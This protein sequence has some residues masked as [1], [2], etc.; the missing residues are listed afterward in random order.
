MEDG[1]VVA[2]IRHE[3]GPFDYAGIAEV[4]EYLG[5]SKQTVVNWRRSFDDWPQ[6]IATLAMG[7]IYRLCDIRDWRRAQQPKEEEDETVAEASD[8]NTGLPAVRHG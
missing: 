5:V 3:H 2:S 1:Q 6:P 8:D 4:A 7:P